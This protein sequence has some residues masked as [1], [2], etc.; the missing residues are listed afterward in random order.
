[1][2]VKIRKQGKAS[3]FPYSLATTTPYDVACRDDVASAAMN[4]AR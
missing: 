1:M 4:I 3:A 2:L